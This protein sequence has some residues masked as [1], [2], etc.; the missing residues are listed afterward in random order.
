MDHHFAITHQVAERYT[1]GDLS[2]DEREAFE[3]HYFDCPECGKAVRDAV[4]LGD[5]CRA[6]FSRNPGGVHTER[7]TGLRLGIWY[8]LRRPVSWTAAAAALLAGY[9]GYLHFVRLPLWT[10]G[11]T[12]AMNYIPGPVR[13]G[14]EVRKLQKSPAGYLVSTDVNPQQDYREYRWVILRPDGSEWLAQSAPFGPS[15]TVLL[16]AGKAGRYKFV[17]RGREPNGAVSAPIHEFE[18]AIE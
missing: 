9:V 13:A 1:L 8:W 4:A 15:L 12:V 18:F 17:I 16:P 14:G 10:K 3:Q 7:P 5:H 6:W 2:A 11:Q